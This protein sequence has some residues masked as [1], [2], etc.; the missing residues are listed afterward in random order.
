MKRLIKMSSRHV[1]YILVMG[2]I[3]LGLITLTGCCFIG[4]SAASK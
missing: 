4:G 1:F 3:S 2:I